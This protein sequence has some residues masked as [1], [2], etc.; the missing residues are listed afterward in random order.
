MSMQNVRDRRSRSQVKTIFF[1]RVGVQG[2]LGPGK[3][4]WVL[5]SLYVTLQRQWYSV[6]TWRYWCWEKVGWALK[7]RWCSW[8]PGAMVYFIAN[9]IRVFCVMPFLTNQKIICL[10]FWLVEIDQSGLRLTNQWNWFVSKKFSP[11]WAFQ[12]HNSSVNSQ[13]ATTWCTK[14]DVA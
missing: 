1:S 7:Y 13:M 6:E 9:E 10:I 8:C 11:I 3:V 2:G 14:L 12:D 4:A 5:S